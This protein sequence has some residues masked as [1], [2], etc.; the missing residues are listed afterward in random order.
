[1]RDQFYL[2]SPWNL[3]SLSERDDQTFN[4]DFTLLWHSLRLQQSVTQKDAFKETPQ[5]CIVSNT[6][7]I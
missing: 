3:F 7:M 2:S 4:L 6:S 1:M 5:V